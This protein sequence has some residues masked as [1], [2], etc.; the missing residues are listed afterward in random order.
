[1]ALA[2][3]ALLRAEKL[4]KR[5]ARTGF[6]WAEPAPVFDKLS[7]ETDELREALASGDKVH[8]EEEMGDLLIVCANLARCI[9]V[10]PEVALRKAN[11]KFERRFRAMETLAAENGDDFVALTLDQQEALWTDVK[12]SE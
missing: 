11:S 8:I 10:D 12:A 4:T 7:E 3:P 1:M 5:A 2:L 6:D 9:G